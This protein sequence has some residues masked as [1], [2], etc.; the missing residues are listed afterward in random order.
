MKQS[1]DWHGSLSTQPCHR[2]IQ[3]LGVSWGPADSK[4]LDGENV[5]GGES[6]VMG[7][8]P[9]RLAAGLRRDVDD[10]SSAFHQLQS[11]AQHLSKIWNRSLTI[12]FPNL[13]RLLLYIGSCTLPYLYL[14]VTCSDLIWCNTLVACPISRLGGGSGCRGAGLI[15][16]ACTSPNSPVTALNLSILDPLSCQSPAKVL[17]SEEASRSGG[18]RRRFA[19]PHGPDPAIDAEKTSPWLRMPLPRGR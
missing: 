14:G 4:R 6:Q 18:Q 5:I 9:C 17:Q 7:R 3:G 13:I 11:S 2:V 1:R 10:A 8:M 15:A 19:I 12:L 16:N